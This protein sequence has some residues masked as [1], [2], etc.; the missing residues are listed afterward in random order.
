MT[1][2]SFESESGF[3]FLPNEIVD[4]IKEHAI[5]MLDAQGYIRSWNNGAFK[6]KGYKKEEIIG[7]HFSIFYPDDLVAEQVP[8]EVLKQAILNGKFEVEGWRKRKDG[9]LFWAHV[10]VEALYD[11]NENSAGFI[12]ITRDITHLKKEKD[13]LKESED[14]YKLLIE[15]IKEYAVISLDTNGKVVVWNAGAEVLYGYKEKNILGKHFSTFYTSDSV[16][17]GYPEYELQKAREDGDFIDKGWR[18]RK[19]G[20]LFFSSVFLKPLYGPDKTIIGYSKIIKDLSEKNQDEQRKNEN[21]DHFRLLIENISDYAIYMLNE[22]GL[23]VTWNKGAKKIKGYSE[24]EIIG[25]SLT[26]FYT[27]QSIEEGV[28]TYELDQARIFGRFEAEGWRIRKG[29]KLFWASYILGSILKDNNLIGYYNITRDLTERKLAEKNLYESEER[30]KLLLNSVKDYAIFI[31]DTKGYIVTWNKGA[32]RIKGYS[33]NEI[34]GKHF[35]I[36]YP[37]EAIRRGHPENELVVAQRDGRSEEEAWRLKKDGSLV[38]VNV[39]LSPIY[40]AENVL[41]GYSK[42]TRDLTEKKKVDDALKTTITDL[43]NFIYTASHDLKSPITNLEGLVNILLQEVSLSNIKAYQLIQM[44][45]L[46]INKFKETI[47]DLTEISRIQRFVEE[48]V[49]PLRFMDFI[50]EFKVSNSILINENKAKIVLDLEIKEI[51]FSKKNLRSIISNLLLNSIKYKHFARRPEILIKTW[52]VEEFTVLS[53]QDNGLG[54]KSNEV[55]KA[56]AMFKRLH[57][58]VPGSGIGLYIIKRIVENIGGKIEVE[59]T[60]GEGTTFKVFLPK[61]I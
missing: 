47:S 26:T 21:E 33:E 18:V 27:R 16:E 58:H 60:V 38:W 23:V 22:N 5:F 13:L 6:I 43:D 14:R 35:S 34:I 49:E 28:P 19:D 55:S 20:S 3:N 8:D 57:D 59:S 12:K 36:F 40:N 7:K 25:K 51:F 24:K 41:I 39:V 32:E 1:R 4:H 61:M 56:F 30:Y 42:I 37:D 15:S 2:N 48:D 10:V 29:G 44:I 31:L 54:M 9:N 46:S 53:V 17:A 50:D 52:A 11:E 45:S